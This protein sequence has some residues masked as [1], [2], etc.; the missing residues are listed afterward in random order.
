MPAV[1]T[2]EESA[3]VLNA[4]I[5]AFDNISDTICHAIIQTENTVI[6]ASGLNAFMS[7]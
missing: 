7:H 3:Q 2:F 5:K 6:N 1:L 4:A